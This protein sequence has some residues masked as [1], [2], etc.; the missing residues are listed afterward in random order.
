[1]PS[2]FSKRKFRLPFFIL[3]TSIMIAGNLSCT[4]DGNPAPPSYIDSLKANAPTR[5]HVIAYNRNGSVDFDGYGSYQIDEANRQI[6]LFADDITTTSYYDYLTEVHYFNS[7][8][9]LTEIFVPGNAAG[10]ELKLKLLRNG[11]TLYQQIDVDESWY[12]LGDTIHVAYKETGSDIRVG[13]SSEKFYSLISHEAVISK[14]DHDICLFIND[15]TLFLPINKKNIANV[16][17]DY[18]SERRLIRRKELGIAEE[19]NIVYDSHSNNLQPFLHH[20]LL[21]RDYYL[22]YP[23]VVLSTFSPSVV[24][25]IELAGGDASNY[26]YTHYLTLFKYASYFKSVV[27]KYSSGG[28]TQQEQFDFINSYDSKDR[29]T[30]M[31]IMLNGIQKYYEISVEY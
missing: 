12:G 23:D 8:W 19:I 15:T 30:K 21:G 5:I 11:N 18:D 22:L 16:I 29:L 26:S 6:K 7:D 20:A 28:T 31:V 10:D 13:Q 1:M 2:F 27:H 9:Y 4:K 25:E 17:L 3:L 14:D 24:P